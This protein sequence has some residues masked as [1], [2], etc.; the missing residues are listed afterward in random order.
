MHP[1][2][3]PSECNT[4]FV[5]VFVESPTVQ[6]EWVPVNT[7]APE[8][9]DSV[10][11]NVSYKCCNDTSWQQRMSTANTSIA[12]QLNEGGCGIENR[13]IFSINVE[14]SNSSNRYV[15]VDF[16]NNSGM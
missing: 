10:Q 16:L 4:E 3:I 12:V 9:P 13:A 2:F 5:E 15:T 7:S 14:G 1:S 6:L 11:Y 8:C